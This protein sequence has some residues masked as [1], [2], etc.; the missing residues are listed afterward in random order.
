MTLLSLPNELLGRIVQETMP[1]GFENFVLSCKAVYNTS[2]ILLEQ[3]NT[4][5]RRYK[6]FKYRGAGDLSDQETCASS[7]QLIARIAAD[8]LIAK[9]MVSADFKEDSIPEDEDNVEALV[10][11]LENSWEVRSLFDDSPYLKEAGV[12]PSAALRYIVDQC[13]PEE[14]DPSLTATLLLSL[15]PNVTEIAL[16]KEWEQLESNRRYLQRRTEIPW[17]MWPLLEA[18]VK[19]ANDPSDSSAGLSKLASLLPS[20]AW[21]YENRWKLSTFTPFLS[22]TSLRR[23]CA[24][25]CRAIDDGYTGAAFNIPEY[26]SFGMGLEVVELA[27]AV[28]D[29]RE[30]LKFL[31]RLPRLKTF[32]LSYETKWHGCGHNYDAGAAMTAIEDSVGHQ[33]EEL[34][35]SILNCFG[36]IESR[37]MSMKEFTKLK[38]LGLDMEALPVYIGDQ[39]DIHLNEIPRLCDLLP[40]TVESLVLLAA[41]IRDYTQKF[42]CLFSETSTNLER[43]LPKLKRIV[44]RSQPQRSDVNNSPG[45]EDMSGEEQSWKKKLRALE[46]LVE[47]EFMEV[48]DDALPQFMERFCHRYE[49]EVV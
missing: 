10:Q 29:G 6:H 11:L 24:G 35:F 23:F 21:G 39:T 43:K 22:I 49:V 30:L 32:R 37:V 38:R 20:A 26:K 40:P 3:H 27:G 41:Q 16:P 7:P 13:V 46:P 33:L 15:L 47:V 45:M 42:A 1:E 17:N 4:M 8:P 28:V 5:R 14:G 44:I 48:N 19:R 36:D 25:S 34:S 2:G 12:D 31:P 9:Y 18:I